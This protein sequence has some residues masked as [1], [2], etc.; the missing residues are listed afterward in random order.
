MCLSLV[1]ML[2][3]QDDG[4]GRIHFVNIAS[5]A[6]QP[7]ENEG[8]LYEEAMEVG[9]CGWP[10]GCVGGWMLLAP[11]TDR[12]KWLAGAVKPCSAYTASPLSSACPCHNAS[13]V[14]SIQRVGTILKPPAA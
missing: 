11:P 7:G 4:A 9:R 13:L 1:S 3:R 5:M 12:P 2:R 6:Y 8:I 14:C 10:A